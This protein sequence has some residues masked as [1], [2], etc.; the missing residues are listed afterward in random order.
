[1]QVYKEDSP[2]EKISGYDKLLRAALSLPP[3]AR[4]QL[5][6]ELF[7]SLDGENQKEIDAAWGEEAERR[8]R[9]IKEGKVEPIDGE[10]VMKEFGRLH[11]TQNNGS[12]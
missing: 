6:D 12:N 7:A 3:A 2:E 10:L 11:R 5:A 4:A 1:M 8:V 9:E